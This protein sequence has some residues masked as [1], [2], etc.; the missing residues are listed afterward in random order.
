M[1]EDEGEELGYAEGGSG[2][3]LADREERERQGESA[4]QEGA[5]GEV[6]EGQRWVGSEGK[7]EGKE[8]HNPPTSR[9]AS[10]VSCRSRFERTSP[11]CT[12]THFHPP[13]PPPSP[14]SSSDELPSI[15]VA[16]AERVRARVGLRSRAER[17]PDGLAVRGDDD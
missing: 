11:S 5:T 9:V 4:A 2:C 1:G 7:G 13:R 15:A 3:R 16:V 17:E 12:T 6:K 14:P 8:T 10:A